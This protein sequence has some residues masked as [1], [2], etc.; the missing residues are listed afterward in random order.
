MTA[1]D[2]FTDKRGT[3]SNAPT[4][5]KDGNMKK[6]TFKKVIVYAAVY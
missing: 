5:Q 1:G 2:V 4:K 3:D 6:N